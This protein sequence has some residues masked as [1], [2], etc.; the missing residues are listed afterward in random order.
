MK[1][2]RQLLRG[3]RWQLAIPYVALLL[4]GRALEMGKV[5]LLNAMPAR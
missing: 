3:L 1:R 2:S 4:A 5:A